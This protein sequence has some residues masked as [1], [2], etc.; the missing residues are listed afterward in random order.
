MCT[1]GLS[2]TF[3][4]D[5]TPQSFSF[6]GM[7]RLSDSS[8]NPLQLDAC[9]YEV[10]AKE[11]GFKSGNIIVRI[12]DMA[13]LDVYLNSGQ[14]KHQAANVV[15]DQVQQYKEYSVDMAQG[16]AFVIVVPKEGVSTSSIQI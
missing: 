11:F 15:S 8:G 12:N 3:I 9:T 5:S 14:N 1:E 6:S 4:A 10:K 16:S 13:S 2:T 7:G